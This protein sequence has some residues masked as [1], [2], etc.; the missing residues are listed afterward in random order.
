MVAQS[1]VLSSRFD[2]PSRLEFVT[3]LF[4]VCILKSIWSLRRSRTHCVG[5]EVNI[6][7]IV[8]SKFRD[9]RGFVGDRAKAC[10]QRA[11][12]VIE[13]SLSRR[14]AQRPGTDIGTVRIIALMVGFALWF[15]CHHQLKLRELVNLLVR[16]Y[17]YGWLKA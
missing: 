8:C 7:G 6:L 15:G 9:E 12:T 11:I 5:R 2:S 16:V 1:G 3:S 14:E 17:R 4:L 13:T 10:V